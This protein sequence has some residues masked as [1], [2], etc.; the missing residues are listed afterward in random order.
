MI[1]HHTEMVDGRAILITGKGSWCR[2]SAL[3]I[4]VSV[5]RKKEREIKNKK[6]EYRK[7]KRGGK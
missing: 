5:K 7:G 6:K 4:S 1:L 2:G 3:T